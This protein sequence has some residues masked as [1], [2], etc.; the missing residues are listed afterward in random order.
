MT[1][2]YVCIKDYGTGFMK[3]VS[4]GDFMIQNDSSN[5]FRNRFRPNFSL[6]E[7][8]LLKHKD[9]FKLINKE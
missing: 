3:P 6:Y 4:K 7:F 2:V 9:H 8:T 1:K 5:L